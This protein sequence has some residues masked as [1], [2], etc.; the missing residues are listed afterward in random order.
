[1][2]EEDRTKIDTFFEVKTSVGAW[3]K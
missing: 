1:L 3:L 2:T